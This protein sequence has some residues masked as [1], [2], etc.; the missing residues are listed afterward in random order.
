METAF[1]AC[2]LFGL[3]FTVVSVALG[4]A[5]SLAGAHGGHGGH[6]EAGQGGHGAHGP[7][8][9]VELGNLDHGGH[10]TGHGQAAHATGS[11]HGGPMAI[12]QQL[13][14]LNFASLVA[15][16]TWFGAAGYAL[17]R[18]AAWPLLLA[19]LAAVLA[20]SAGALLIAL[21][22]GKVMAGERVLD[23]RDD[24]LPGTL[25]RVTVSIPDHGVG[26]IVFTKAGRRRSEAARSV[27]GRAIPRGTEVVILDY[28]RGV[29]GVQPWQELLAENP[30]GARRALPAAQG[31]VQPEPS[32][33]PAAGD[34]PPREGVRPREPY[35]ESDETDVATR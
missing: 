28:S 27:T 24:R 29:A 9:H 31:A 2:F 30:S 21:F 26:E 5:G 13:P 12:L 25:A 6:F 11:H 23:P 34:R 17:V 10:A 33:E 7:G 32:D 15:F 1:L 14:L 3:L 35:P 4:M 20:G 19:I 8:H 22:L 16:L 18:F